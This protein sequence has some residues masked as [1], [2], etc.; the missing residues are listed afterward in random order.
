MGIKYA[1]FMVAEASQGNNSFA[2][3][4]NTEFTSIR[5]DS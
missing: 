5:I 2:K 4:I 3:V 1:R